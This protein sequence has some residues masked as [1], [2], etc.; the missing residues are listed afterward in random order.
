MVARMNKWRIVPV[1]AVAIALACRAALA[2][3]PALDVSQYAHTSW[4][5]RDGF[6]RGTINAI[7]QTTD[8]YLWIAT[9]FGLYRF[10]GVRAVHWQPPAGSKL[11]DDRVFGLLAARDGAL[12]IGTWKGLARWKDGK[13]TTYAALA[14]KTITRVV[15][16]HDGTVWVGTFGILDAARLC[17]I[18]GGNVRCHGEDGSLGRAIFGLYEDRRR[19]LWVG[20]MDGFWRWEAGPREFFSMPG[21]TNGVRAFAESD[22]GTLLI[23]SQRGVKRLAGG[24]VEQHPLIDTSARLEDALLRDRDG[25]LWAAGPLRGLAHLHNAR[26]DWYSE[27]DGLSGQGSAGLLEDREGNIWVGTTDG[28]DQFRPYVAHTISVKQGLRNA[29]A[30]SALADRNGAVWI[31]TFDG[32]YKWEHG[33]AS[34]FGSGVNANCLFEDSNGRIWVT[35]LHEFGYLEGDRFV[36][37]RGVPGGVVHGIAELPSGHLWIAN[38]SLGLMQVFHGRM[39]QKVPWSAFGHKDHAN[40][41][42]ADYSHHGLWLGFFLGGV[43]YFEGDRIRASYSGANGLASGIVN[44]LRVD[45]GGTLW[46]AAEGGLSRIKDGRVGTLTSK[47]GLPCDGASWSVEDDSHDL[48]VYMTCGLLRI[49]AAE[50][51]AWAANPTA[52]M[53]HS[54][55]FDAFDGVRS[56]A[57]VGGYTP[58]VT[59]SADGRIWFLPGDGV[60]VVDPRHLPINKVAPPVRIEQIVADGKTH[61]A[62]SALRLPPNVRNLEIDYTALSFVVPAKMHFRFKLEG[63]DT[64]WREVVNQRRVEYSNLPPRHYRFRVIASNNSGVWNEQGAALD[65][66][67]APAF[68]QTNWFRVL[69]VAAFLVLLWTLYRLRVQQLWRQQQ[70][71]RDVIETMPTLAFTALPDGSIDFVNS[72]RKAYMGLSTWE[73]AAHPADVNRHMEKW[74]A[75]LATG[76]PFENEVRYRRSSDGEYR[77]FLTRAVALR[78]ARG[79]IVKWYGI[80]TDIDDRK[81]AEQERETLRADLAH[82]NRVSMMGELA[83]SLSHE[84]KQPI[85]AT[86]I[87]ADAAIR[88]LTREEPDLEH[89]RETAKRII[90]DGARATEIIDRLRS[91]YKKAPPQHELVDVRETIDEM[92]VLLRGEANRCGV[93]IRTDLAADLARITADRV[94][95]QQVLMN[96]MLNAI[97]A[98]KETGGV[99]TIQAQTGEE[100]QIRISVSD[101]GVGL[102]PDKADEIFNAFFTTKPQGSGM[103]LAISR[104]I[105]ESHGGRLWATAND[106]RGATFHFTLPIAAA[107]AQSA[108]R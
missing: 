55:L 90:K 53:I 42:A 93:S 50:V 48:W 49:R 39:I 87:N 92:V 96:L 29:L 5:I 8:G 82:M 77:W 51:D 83:A 102:P 56:H 63:Q 16:D 79:R 14:G 3:D 1:V 89:A 74:R 2:L 66:A 106:G 95:L 73:D 98:M 99:L 94:Q 84:L 107:A 44:D 75:S 100:G 21:E 34:R 72:H 37:A 12:W 58:R 6:A 85:A 71:L 31:S 7:A 54:T 40:A 25:G 59:K 28:I 67:I 33:Q 32:L 65:F 26:V 76:E 23:A 108:A 18:R 88:W 11:P 69:A 104:S 47:N 10:D 45:D 78:D 57:F 27:T 68:Y 15:E 43:A 91:L 36:A 24:R 9:E 86:I 80:S 22:D 70:K 35:T 52:A 61:D 62:A 64:D 101:T 60:S 19:N 4:K 41:L 38:Q 103:G 30:M 46:V 81:R 17:E 97:E 13:L 105:V 20:G